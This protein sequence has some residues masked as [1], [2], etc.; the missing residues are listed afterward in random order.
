MYSK[1]HRFFKFQH[2]PK[3]FVWGSEEIDLCRLHIG[4]NRIM[5]SL[6]DREWFSSPDGVWIRHDCLDNQIA[7]WF[8]LR[9]GNE[10]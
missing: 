2:V 8:A 4:D 7:T 6:V 5:M 1:T 3:E 9:A 10:V